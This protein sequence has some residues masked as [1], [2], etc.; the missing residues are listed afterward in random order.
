MNGEQMKHVL[1]D[2]GRVYGM[3]LALARNP[4]WA[5]A[6]AESGLDY[7]IIDTEHSAFSRGEVADMI[8]AF[9]RV[10]IAPLVRVPIPD[11][12]YVTM[13]MDAGAH[14]VL[15]PYCEAAGEARDVVGAAKWRPL[16][17]ALLD[18]VLETGEFP[19]Q[20]VEEYLIDRNRDS[21]VIVGIES[22]PAIDNLDAILDVP[23]I[24]VIFVGP[25]DLSVSVG[26]PEQYDHPAFEG[27][28]RIASRFS[29]AGVLSMPI[30]TMA[31]RL[32]SSR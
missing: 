31:S 32:R 4:R 2:G 23:G 30:I 27:T 16:K 15:A 3:M 26:V 7:L 28:S 22:V 24:D 9:D 18:R 20:A 17:G 10:G 1:S 14:G 6:L 12:H 25:H 21:V 19:S 5:G 11:A 13:V 29:T 8:P